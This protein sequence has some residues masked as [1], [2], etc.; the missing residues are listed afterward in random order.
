MAFDHS[1]A[2]GVDGNGR[3]AGDSC[4]SAS[5]VYSLRRIEIRQPLKGEVCDEPQ[6]GTYDLATDLDATGGK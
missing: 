3:S 6:I 4:L 2:G 5:G 1:S